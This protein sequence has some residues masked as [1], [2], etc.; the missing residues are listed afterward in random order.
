MKNFLM[1]ALL[2]VMLLGVPAAQLS[3]QSLLSKLAKSATKSSQAEAADTTATAAE[4]DSVKIDW[5]AIPVYHPQVVVETDE[6]GQPLLNAD[7]T[8][9]TRVL[10]VDQFGNYRS[11]EAVDA[12]RK[13]LK[14]YLG[15]IAL[16]VGGGAL[17][18]AAAGFLSG[19]S[20]KGA[21]TAIGAGAGAAAGVLLSLN[22]IKQ[23]KALHKS[24]KEQD[25]MMEAY[26]KS[27]TNEGVA[28][29]AS[30]NIESIEGLNLD[31]ST[32]VSKTASEIKE[33]VESDEFNT[34]E[35]GIWD[36]I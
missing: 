10:F 24:L 5:D 30:A 21:A 17:A 23:A 29:D 26:R 4:G 33:M 9:Q 3:A 6:S 12:Q 18:G 8:Q 2:A 22:D 15:N 31:K 1:K 36:S 7:G 28:I 19:G 20:K 35:A 27:F 25:K 11:Q 16:K 32:A 14:K 34:P 13:K